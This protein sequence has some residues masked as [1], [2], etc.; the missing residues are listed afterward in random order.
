[1]QQDV[2]AAKV[3]Q[4]YKQL[5]LVPIPLIP[6]EKRPRPEGWQRG[7]F[8]NAEDILDH[9]RT[10]PNDGIGLV[11][12]Q[13]AG[14]FVLDVD[15]KSGGV[16]SLRALV[17]EFGPLP[18]TVEAKTG[19]GGSHYVF[20]YPEGRAI[21][22]RTGVRPGLDV[23]AGSRNDQGKLE[24]AG[25][26]AVW[27]TVHPSGN[28]YQW[29]IPPWDSDMLE[30]PDWLL[31]LIEAPQ[32]PRSFEGGDRVVEGERHEFLVHEAARLRGLGYDPQTIA[33][34]L[35]TLFNQRCEL[36]PPMTDGE[37][38]DIAE[39]FEGKATS[40]SSVARARASEM[41][42]PRFPLEALPPMTRSVVSKLAEAQDVSVDYVGVRAVGVASGVIGTTA[43]IGVASAW[44]PQPASIFAAIVGPPGSAKTEAGWQLSEPV[45]RRQRQ[46]DEQFAADLD[47]YDA[48]RDKNKQVTSDLKRQHDDA[49]KKAL[50]NGT[51]IPKP[52]NGLFEKSNGYEPVR[53]HAWTESS[54]VEGL[55][56]ALFTSPRGLLV[57]PDELSKLWLSMNKYSGGHGND[58][59]HYLE[60]WNAGRWKIKRADRKGDKQI[61]KAYLTIF[62]GIQPDLLG[63]LKG[64]YD[65]GTF[66]RWLYCWPEVNWLADAHE[67]VDLSFLGAW[68]VLVDRLYELTG[69]TEIGL[70]DEA[71]AERR[72][73]YDGTKAEWS[74]GLF[75]GFNGKAGQYWARLALI[76]HMLKW[77]EDGG[78]D[79]LLVDFESA[80]GASLL[81]GYFYEMA[82]KVHAEVKSDASDVSDAVR[83]CPRCG[84]TFKGKR[85]DAKFCSSNCRKR[86][87][88]EK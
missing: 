82:K 86:S 3:A 65:D 28:Q 50:T 34:M 1:M 62:G 58:K 68:D 31:D 19:G 46:L 14:Y 23:R 78:G 85:Q 16:E 79:Y 52:P 55:A 61:D 9:W 59:Q 84:K 87:S 43:T 70:D 42:T 72:K 49:V 17:E 57:I 20:I 44:R 51:A 73:F 32:P 88:E 35:A 5:G 13:D 60:A 15:V 21:K 69:E 2:A 24:G 77:A 12:G 26:I 67:G 11:C 54:T 29:V 39:W 33:G 48:A 45:Y 41:P 71:Q 47:A 10:H 63:L 75:R 18:G 4:H 36:D 38:R 76:L 53:Q 80:R 83:V 8:K 74:R 7:Y 25:Q 27:P 81:M 30:A 64:E 6:G 40:E 22:S 66:E 56:D 37:I